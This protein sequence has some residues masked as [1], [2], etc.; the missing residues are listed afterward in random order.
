MQQDAL[1]VNSPES[2]FIHIEQRH[3]RLTRRAGYLD[4]IGQCRTIIEETKSPDEAQHIL[5]RWFG[6]AARKNF[7]FHS[8]SPYIPQS[9]KTPA[10]LTFASAPSPVAVQQLQLQL[11]RRQPQQD[12]RVTK[13]YTRRGQQQMQL[14]S[15]ATAVRRRTRSKDRLPTSSM[16]SYKR[17]KKQQEMA[18]VMQQYPVQ[19][20]VEE[21]IKTSR[22][23]ISHNVKT[24][25]G[26]S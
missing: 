26:Y 7:V 18:L 21:A 9:P 2:K 1:L 4:N 14:A 23:R 22:R 5:K 10:Q 15:T 20:G 8:P 17:Y 24:S 6:Y 3:N 19:T 25:V 12:A 11:Y 13:S 16:L